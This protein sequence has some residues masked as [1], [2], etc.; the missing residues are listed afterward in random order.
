MGGCDLRNVRVFAAGLDKEP[1]SENAIHTTTSMGPESSF[2]DKGTFVEDMFF[3]AGIEGDVASTEAKGQSKMVVDSSHG[4]G[5]ITVEEVRNMEF[6]TLGE[7]RE[8]Y[9]GYS[10]VKGFPIRKSKME[11]KPVTKCGC[12]TKLRIKQNAANGKWCVERFLDNHNHTLLPE[13]FVG[14]LPV[15]RGMSDVETAQ[16]NMLR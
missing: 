14:Y 4:Y 5:H 12:L 10:R 1:S 16:T 3:D 6:G 7:A 2:S 8:F 11:Y 13:I 15:H 9:A